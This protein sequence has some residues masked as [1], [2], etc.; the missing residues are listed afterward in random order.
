ME[1]QITYEYIALVCFACALLHTFSVRIFQK[2]AHRYEEGTIGENLLHLLGEIEIVFGLWAFLFL[3]A[4]GISEGIGP[5]IGYLEGQSFIE[6]A[7]VFVIMAVASTRPILDLTGRLIEF[8]GRLLPFSKQMGFYFACLTIGPLLGSF[9]TEPAAM[10]VTAVLLLGRFY[11]QPMSEKFKY[12]TLG[13]LFVNVSIGGTLTPYAAPPVLMVADKW[14]WDLTFMLQNFGWKAAN[15]IC[16]ATAFV[17]FRY[18][19]ELNSIPDPQNESSRS[20]IPIWISAVHLLALLAIVVS[21]HH[22]ILFIG[23]FLLFLGIYNVTREYQHELKLRE[24]LLV[25]FFLGGLVVL[26]GPQKWWLQPILSGLRPLSLYFGAIGLTAFTDNAA[27]TFL[28]S[29]VPT[30][31]DFAKY[32]LVAGSVVGGGLTVIANAPNPAGYGIL[33]PAFGEDGINPVLLLIGAM[34]PT[35]FAMIFLFP[36]G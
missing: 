15:A 14:N 19:S 27:L 34:P 9:I 13:L 29:Q 20:K 18:R 30:L 32:S 35:F 5:A 26:G 22:M 6:P 21:A 8:A 23:I 2:W 25:G 31:S 10:T 36:Y 17:A 33:N 1:N 16:L 4:L 11:S 7:F 28:G 3:L 12:S 24:S